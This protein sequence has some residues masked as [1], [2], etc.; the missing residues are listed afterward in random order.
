M[1]IVSATEAKTHFGRYLSVALSEPVT[2]SKTG[3]ETIV[4]I[5]KKEYDRLEACENAYWGVRALLAEQSGYL[6]EDVGQTIIKRKKMSKKFIQNVATTAICITA[7]FGI[8]TV[9]SVGDVF[10]E[11][12]KEDIKSRGIPRRLV[13]TNGGYDTNNVLKHNYNYCSL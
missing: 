1:K 7:I 8:N 11:M 4:M 3:Q 2:V 10:L 13:I 5:S 12:S 9:H 6:G